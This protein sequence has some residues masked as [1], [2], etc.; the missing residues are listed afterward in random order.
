MY[1]KDSFQELRS[2]VYSKAIAFG[3]PCIVVVY[4]KSS[5]IFRIDSVIQSVVFSNALIFLY[6]YFQ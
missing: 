3:T 6:P 4:Q 2:D 5:F 1:G